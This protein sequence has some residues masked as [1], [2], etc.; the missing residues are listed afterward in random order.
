MSDLPKQVQDRMAFRVKQRV[1][2][3]D[4]YDQATARVID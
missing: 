1:H 3:Q 4:I 2:I